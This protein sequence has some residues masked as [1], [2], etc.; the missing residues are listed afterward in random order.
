MD[1]H[2]NTKDQPGGLKAVAGGL[3]QFKPLHGHNMVVVARLKH[4][5]LF[6]IL[7]GSQMWKHLNPHKPVLVTKEEDGPGRKRDSCRPARR[8]DSLCHPSTCLSVQLRI[9]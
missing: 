3:L 8:A 5:F 2:D 9:R 7:V 1:A 6:A 4:L